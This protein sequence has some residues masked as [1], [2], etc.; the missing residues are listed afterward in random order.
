MPKIL[1]PFHLQNIGSPE[2]YLIDIDEKNSE[3]NS[4]AASLGF[5][6]SWKGARDTWDYRIGEW[7]L[8][9]YRIVRFSE[10]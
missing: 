1:N 9:R 10:I 7:D 8:V 5:T 2:W 6:K 4:E 3:V